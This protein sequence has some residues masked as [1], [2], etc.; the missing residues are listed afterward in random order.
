MINRFIPVSSVLLVAVL[1]VGCKRESQPSVAAFTQPNA[2]VAP[3]GTAPVY[4]NNSAAGPSGQTFDTPAAGTP[5]YTTPYPGEGTRSRIDDRAT[6]VAYSNPRTV[7]YRRSRPV[8]IHQQLAPSTTERETVTERR[9]VT[10]SGPRY[11][12]KNR[13]KKKSAAI[14]LGSAG[15]GAAIGALAGGG[16]GAGIGA[17]AGGVGGLIY[18]RM[19]A[20]KRVVY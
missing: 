18:D 16:K 12:V 5:A 15:A 19:T 1:F 2:A 3:N 7:R 10:Y 14:V 20:H 17:L 8:I 6:T 4:P 9:A 13:T 11:V